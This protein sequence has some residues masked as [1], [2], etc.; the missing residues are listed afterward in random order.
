MKGGGGGVNAEPLY[1]NHIWDEAPIPMLFYTSHIFI[2][3][4]GCI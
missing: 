2:S 4:G 1:T 3:G